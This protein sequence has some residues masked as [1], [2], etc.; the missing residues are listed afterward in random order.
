M[1]T[2]QTLI[3][4]A[5]EVRRLIDWP[6]AIGSAR[7]TLLQLTRGRAA[8][9]PKLY[10]TLP[11]GDDF[12]AM[13]ARVAAPAACGIKW[14]NVHAR[15]PRRGLPTV[16]AVIVL[17]DPATG[18]PLAVMDGVWITKVRTAAAAAVAAQALS[19]RESRRVA[20]IGCGAQADAQ[21]FALRQVR[22]FTEVRVWGHAPG[23][24]ARFCARMR[25]QLPGVA[26]APAATVQA[27]VAQADLIITL[28]P[29]RRPLVRAGWVAPGTHIN[30][31]GADAP[32]KQELDPA[33]LRR[34][35]VVVDDRAQSIHA[36]EL[37]MPIA[38]GQY[39][40][41][42][43][44]GTLGDV[45]IRRRAGRCSLREITIFDSTG[46]AVH[47]VA[48][49]AEAYRRASR[50]RMGRRVPLVTP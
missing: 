50:R 37:N 20:L 21:L 45:L 22:R 34:A 11:S 49:A 16:M 1:R 4:T 42:C 26:L 9:P 35:V 31:I 48:L 3:L 29:S 14:V 23:E 40:P 13:P 47:D 44:R 33:L 43:I 7:A 5:R 46:L 19:R 25:R 32:G 27:A 30:A 39:Q 28:T 15:N 24:A 8:M 12:R 6:M 38:R 41:A 36:G 17:N 18:A 10:L 2:P